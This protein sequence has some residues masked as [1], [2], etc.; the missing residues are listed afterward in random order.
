ME[1]LDNTL[2]NTLERK[3]GKGSR[4]FLHVQLSNILRTQ[5]ADRTYRVGDKL[6]SEVELGKTYNVNRATVR[7]ALQKLMSE[8]LIYR[9]PA[10]GTFV[11]DN[12]RVDAKYTQTAEGEINVAWVIGNGANRV[13]GPFHALL[14]SRVSS[15]LSRYQQHLVFFSTDQSQCDDLIIANIRQKKIQAMFLVGQFPNQ[16]FDRFKRLNVP[17]VLLDNSLSDGSIDCVIADNEKGAYDAVCRLIE[18]GHRRIAT[19]RA[20]LTEAA[21]QERF[22]GYMRALT[23]AG[24]PFYEELVVEGNFQSD[25][26][27]AAMEKLL[28]LKFPPTAVF[29]FNDEMA[30]GAMKAIRNHGLRIPEDISIVGFDDIEWS[31]HAIPPLSTVHVPIEEI[32]YAGV[33]LLETRMQRPSTVPYKVLIPARY[34]E[35]ASVATRR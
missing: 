10:S 24:I 4:A 26:G 20:P 7:R 3:N 17:M 34:V 23:D 31:S 8:R 15:E 5:I 25:G 35:R 30:I 14:F 12:A 2:D 16:N 6:P 1:T 21:T 28:A 19:V 11:S 9:I 27:E 13:L 18:K 33:H 32:A 29:S 22:K